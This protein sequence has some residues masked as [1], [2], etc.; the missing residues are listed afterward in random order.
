M[1]LNTLMK[2]LTFCISSFQSSWHFAFC[3]LW[4]TKHGLYIKLEVFST[5]KQFELILWPFLWVLRWIWDTGRRKISETTIPLFYLWKVPFLFST[6][7][8]GCFKFQQSPKGVEKNN[9][10]TTFK[11]QPRKPSLSVVDDMGSSYS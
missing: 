6:S 3:S 7:M 1:E 8:K 2:I 5:N 4:E 10:G 9:T 11:L